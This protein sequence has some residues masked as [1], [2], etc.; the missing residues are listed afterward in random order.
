MTATE[1]RN[2][3][4]A[5]TEAVLASIDAALPDMTFGDFLALAVGESEAMAIRDMIDRAKEL[6]RAS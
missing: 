4:H 2:Q 5:K 6:H 1:L 3:L